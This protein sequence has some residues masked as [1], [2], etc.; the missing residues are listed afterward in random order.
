MSRICNEICSGDQPSYIA[1]NITEIAGCNEIKNYLG[2]DT[3]SDLIGKFKTNK[4]YAETVLKGYC[5]LKTNMKKQNSPWKHTGAEWK[6]MREGWSQE[7]K[8]M[9][10]PGGSTTKKQR[11]RRRNTK[12][13]KRRSNKKK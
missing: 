10:V 13:K 7:E 8:E 2:R 3:Q 9:Y 5:N 1:S 4:A 11:K 12:K 6:D